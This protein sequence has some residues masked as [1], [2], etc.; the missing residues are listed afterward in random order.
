ML[1]NFNIV[2]ELLEVF[3]SVQFSRSVVS[4]SLRPHELQ[5]AR[6]PCPSPTPGVHSDSRPS[7][8]WC[9]PAISL[10]HP[11]LFLPP[12]PPSIR[13]FSNESTLHMR[14]PKYWSFSFSI[15]R[16]VENTTLTCGFSWAAI[17]A[18]QFLPPNDFPNVTSLIYP[19][20]FDS[21]G[22]HT[23]PSTDPAVSH[24]HVFLCLSVP[25][26]RSLAGQP[27]AESASVSS[28]LPCNLVHNPCCCNTQRFVLQFLSGV[29][30]GS[31]L[32]F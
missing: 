25:S 30:L 21:T 19:L 6:P 27:Q 29:V 22:L 32:G 17:W 16:S 18:P 1:N 3:S 23:S 7:S 2:L 31:V 8:R 10:C 13:V 24:L 9:H 11:L 28:G 20:H 26:L 12:I 14:W 4:D 15:I 5:R